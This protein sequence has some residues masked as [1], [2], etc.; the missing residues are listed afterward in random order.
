MVYDQ[1]ISFFS[2]AWPFI[3]AG[4][5]AQLID[6]ALGMAYGVISSTI[7]VSILGVP[8]LRASSGIH[9]AKLFTSGA[10]GVSHILH[11]NVDW[12]LMW[13]IA[14]PGIV[15]GIIGALVLA[16]I[17]P[18][19]AKPFVMAYL[20]SIGI[21]L[22]VRGISL[23]PDVEFKKAKITT[24]LGLAGGFL[25]AIG[26][27]GWG[28]V[29][30]SNLLIQGVEPR[31][32]IGTVNTAEF[33]ITIAI[34]T[35]FIWAVGFKG[36]SYAIIGLIIGGLIAAP[37]GAVLTKRIPPRPLLMAVGFLLTLTSLYS[38]YRAVL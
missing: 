10:S 7:L 17:H 30:T 1:I 36:V 23:K 11:K 21:Y 8:P 34:S 2:E 16:N 38:L 26:G 12:P 13:K 33:L 9:L 20:T 22:M 5:F 29:V 35:T 27:G 31:K 3:L 19:I 28:P 25:D 18:E 24:P 32:T 6:G 4:F 15:G 14:I 37:L